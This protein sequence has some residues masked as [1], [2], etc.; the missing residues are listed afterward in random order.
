MA[1]LELLIVAP[2]SHICWDSAPAACL[3]LLSWSSASL[4]P[5]LAKPFLAFQQPPPAV[6]PG[7]AIPDN[8][9]LSTGGSPRAWS[10]MGF[11]VTQL[12][13]AASDT[14]KD[15]AHLILYNWVHCCKDFGEDE[16]LPE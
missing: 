6:L 15:G 8:L 1:Q 5:L 16:F 9:T 4:T 2:R 13:G 14:L 10:V 7:A 12:R 11:S 3:A